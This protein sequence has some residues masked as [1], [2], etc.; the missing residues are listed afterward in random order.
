MTRASLDISPD[1]RNSPDR[2]L[3]KTIHSFP[4]TRRLPRKRKS[5][6]AD[7]GGRDCKY[8]LKMYNANNNDDCIHS[9]PSSLRLPKKRK[10]G[11]NIKGEGDCYDPTEGELHPI[12]M[13]NKKA[14]NTLEI[15]KQI[16]TIDE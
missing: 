11:R 15:K 3:N 8:D 1:R 4:P 16:C 12:H 2:R 5:W 6:D 10:S 9:L 7:M 14:Q 13:I